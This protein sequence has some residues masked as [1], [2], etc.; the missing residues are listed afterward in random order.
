MLAAAILRLAFVSVHDPYTDE[1]LLGFRAIKLI[2]YDLSLVQTTPWQ[3]VETVPVWM[4]LSFHDHPILFFFLQNLSIRALGES[5]LALRLPSVVSGIAS[6]FLIYLVASHLLNRRAGY[7]AAALLAV[8][9]YHTWVSRLGIQDGAVIFFSLLILWLW[10]KAL[11]QNKRLWWLLWGMALGLG[12][13]TKLTVLIIIP[14]LLTYALIYRRPFFKN[15]FFWQGLGMAALFSSPVWLYNLFLYKNFGHFDF[16]ISAALGQYV[17]KWQFRQ[18]RVMVGGVLPRFRFFFETLYQSNSIIF[19]YLTIFS[20]LGALY[21]FL[22]K[23]SKLALFL[24]S[25]MVLEGLWFLVTGSTLRFVVMIIPYF[26]LLIT[27]IFAKLFEW[28]RFNRI[29]FSVLALF[30]AGELLFTANS[31]LISPSWGK[32]N[33][34][35]A[36][37]NVEMRNFGWNELN[38]YLDNYLAGKTSAAFG[39]PLHQFMV[40]LHNAEIERAARAGREKYALVIIYDYDFNFLSRLWTFQRRLIYYGWPALSDAAFFDITGEEWDGYYRR[41]GIEHFLYFTGVEEKDFNVGALYT[42]YKYKTD[43]TDFEKYLAG[44]GIEPEFIKNH[45]GENAFKVYRF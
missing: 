24:L 31:F 3:W 27:Y 12:V 33:L 23:K 6:V 11:E 38:D 28:G 13:I 25:A 1:V 18:G 40:D 7:I 37:I 36:P 8:Q 41:Q 45:Q 30:L 4:R 17:E 5:M 34:D 21:L 39:K 43:L 14:I 26:V 19:N 44:K 22:K 20:T 42:P 9:S 2:D 32:T 10:L 15:R 16:Q 29:I 35:Y